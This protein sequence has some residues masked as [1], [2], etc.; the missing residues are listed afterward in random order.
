L[1][2][3][4]SVDGL[5][6]LGRHSGEETLGLSNG[7]K[8]LASETDRNRALNNN[9]AARTS[10]LLH[11]TKSGAK[12]RQVNGAVRAKKSGN[13]DEEVSRLAKI[14]LVG[15]ERD[16]GS[17]TELSPKELKTILRDVKAHDLV[18]G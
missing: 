8:K 9:G 11:T 5:A 16:V 2:P 13:R 12:V 18:L 7:T 6:Y 17:S 4:D 1:L 14:R 15:S 10:P 3:K